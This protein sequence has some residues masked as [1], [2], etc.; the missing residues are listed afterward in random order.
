MTAFYPVLN[1][2]TTEYT[3]QNGCGFLDDAYYYSKMKR[4]GVWV[5][6]KQ[7]H[8]AVDFNAITG[9]D[10]DLGDGVHGADGGTILGTTWDRYIGGI[11]ENL[12]TDGSISGYWHLR[13]IHVRKGQYVNGGDL[14]G[15][16]GKGAQLDMS[17][18]LHFYVK[19]PGVD[20]PLGYWPSTHFK[21]KA[22][23]EAFIREHYYDPIAWLKA[24]GAKRTLADLQAQ[25]GE[26]VKV[27]VVHGDDVVDVTGKLVPMPERGMTLDARTATVRL[28]VNQQPPSTIPALPPSR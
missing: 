6:R 3:V 28:Y 19:K 23:C 18:H 25:R 26:P 24:R 11:V 17:A 27:L 21:D 7:V 12:H 16:I 8:P 10:T 20:L 5:P 4:N 13:D 15:Q 9:G 14:L 22:A 1:S 2:P